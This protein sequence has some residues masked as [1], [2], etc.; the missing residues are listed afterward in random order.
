MRREQVLK[1]CLNH[2]L[3][4][5]IDYIKKDDKSWLF[6]AADYSEGEINHEQFCLRFKSPEV[7][8]EFKLAIKKALDKNEDDDHKTEGI[9]SFFIMRK[10]SFACFCI[11]R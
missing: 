10:K 4:N 3:T 6:H 1:I 9:Y 7:A 11:F 8:S 2:N 5:D